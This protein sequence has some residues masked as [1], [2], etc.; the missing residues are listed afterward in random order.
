[1]TITAGAAKRQSPLK[2]DPATGELISQAAHSLGMS[3]KDFVAEA[4]RST[5]SSVARR[6]G[7]A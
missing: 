6:S 7:A 3:R 4:T 5:L 2:V 1:M